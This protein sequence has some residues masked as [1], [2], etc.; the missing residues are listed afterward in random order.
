MERKAD[1]SDYLEPAYPSEL[2]APVPRKVQL[3]SND[4]WLGLMI[5][6]LLFALGGT[7]CGVRCFDAFGQMQKRAALR[8]DGREVV[9]KV[10]ATHRGRG[11]TF[12]RYTFMVNGRYYRGDEQMPGYRLVLNSFD[13][14]TVRYLPSDP[15]VNHPADWEWSEFM[16]LDLTAFSLVPVVIGSIVLVVFLGDRR[17][18]RVGKVAKGEVL[19]CEPNKTQFRVEYEFTAG[20][21]TQ[22]KGAC[23]CWEEYK[24]GESIWILYLPNRPQKNH[25]YPLAFFGV[26]E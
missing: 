15:T 24:V 25:S 14:I 3:N 9:G 18:A 1:G 16:G 5:G 8:R 13:Q 22:T 17:L 23:D 7:V 4:A 6:L 26:A 19:R 12:V 20:N 11:P 10:I 21:G 2:T